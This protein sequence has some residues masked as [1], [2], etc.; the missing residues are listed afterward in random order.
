[1][2]RRRIIGLVLLAC[3]VILLAI[4]GC[5]PSHRAPEPAPPPPR[6]V[7]DSTKPF[8]LRV[9][10][11]NANDAGHEAWL[12]REL[13]SLLSL[14]GLQIAA[15]QPIA[16]TRL[17][18]LQVLY[19][20]TA[21]ELKLIAPD[22]VVEHQESISFTDASRLQV[23]QELLRHLLKVVGHASNRNVELALD[24]EP[25]HFDALTESIDEIEGANSR[26]FTDVGDK[27]SHAQAV[28]KLERI[29]RL[30]PRN[31][32]ALGAL[33]LGYLSVGGPD[34]QSLLDLA[35][36][37]A[38]RSLS[39]NQQFA[40][41]HA[42]LG[43]VA[44][45][46]NQWTSARESLDRALKLE[47]NSLP[48]L[49]G[50]ACVLANA[51]QLGQAAVYAKRTLTLHRENVGARD[52]LSYA[53]PLQPQDATQTSA[54]K[55]AAAMVAATVAMLGNDYSSARELL[56]A[57]TSASAMRSWGESLLDAAQ[58]PTHISIALQR[59]TEAA[60]EDHIDST[61]VLLSGVALQNSDFV[62]N[63]IT[64]LRVDQEPEPLRI[65]W[66]PQA[67]FLR[68]HSRFERIVSDA[69]L[70]AY[71]HEYGRPDICNREPTVYGCSELPPPHP[72][73]SR[74]SSSPR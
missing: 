57:A 32:R 23:T 58:H 64:R 40:D 71:W 74:Q 46:R 35:E 45:R 72:P 25:A 18:E 19:S 44:F 42:A 8:V 27:V 1:M 6:E 41:S 3:I 52:C 39:L 47:P 49:E 31:P 10:S 62:F 73:R 21:A 30:H 54:Q 11:G 70:P 14:A 5:L 38:Q 59:V 20:R 67:A 61:Q 16:P 22:Q 48:A 56:S 29:V 34:H 51:G 69:E 26:G 65:L 50:L 13:N 37:T 24:F 63:R 17:F 36:K 15:S 9:I 66:L 55:S 4:R 2:N 60:L 28:T 43:L 33:A 12:T 53:Q 7:F 68:K